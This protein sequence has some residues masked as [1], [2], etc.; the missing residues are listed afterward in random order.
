MY[1]LDT[2]KRSGRN[3]RQAKARTILTAMAIG[4]GAF[5]LTL[6]LAASN[7]AKTFVG[8]II[9]ENFNPAEL[10][11]A[12]DQ[13]TFDG[14]N[15][16]E[17]KEFS[18]DFSTGLS[19]AGATIQVKKLTARD[20]QKIES[21]E[22]IESIRL[23]I[24]VNLKYITRQD[25]KK[26]VATISALDPFRKFELLAGQNPTEKNEILIPKAW[27]KPLGFKNA[28]S[29]VNQKIT[30][31]AYR[32][33]V[34]QELVE[35]FVISGVM[36]EP[37]AAQQPGTQ[38][39]LYG[40]QEDV[41]R[42]NE[43]ATINT[44]EFQKYNNIF[45]LVED[46]ENEDKLSAVQEKVEEAGF[47]SMS[48]KETQEFLNQVID[49]LQGIVAGFSF[50]AVVASLFGVINTMYISVIQRTRE[51]GLMK[52]L[53]M[54]G[55]DVSR[56]FRFEAAWIGFLGGALGSLLAIGLGKALNPWITRTL[57]LGEGKEL[58]EFHLS[59]VMVLILALILVA[60]VAGLLPARKAAKLDPIE[61]LRT[62]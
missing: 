21:I 55:R 50:I 24:T 19:N 38:L 52:A 1:V 40:I 13:E 23:D 57:E 39:Y 49:V 31:A 53:G 12:K 43:A 22:G 34:T 36:N 25:Q 59:Q 35:E 15:T 41:K 14:P 47:A 32:S 37:S 11:I 46:G 48:I 51:I 60:I 33:N 30:V 9:S 17:P 45:A 27:I 7:G 5:A 54:R 16:T 58:L 3:L 42:L 20:L 18:D 29:A 44:N 2:L 4:V 28:Q 26:Y 10:M 61:A 6:T 8:D 62:E 56:L